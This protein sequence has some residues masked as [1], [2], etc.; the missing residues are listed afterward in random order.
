MEGRGKV[1]K[2]DT[3]KYMSRHWI[4]GVCKKAVGIGHG[5]IG[6]MGEGK[7]VVVSV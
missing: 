5:G 2:E 6:G 1:D 7:K 4:D 3:G